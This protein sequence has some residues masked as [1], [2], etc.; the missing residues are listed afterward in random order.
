MVALATFPAMLN[1]MKRLSLV[2]LLLLFVPSAP[3][4][5]QHPI[6]ALETLYE[7]DVGRS[8]TFVLSARS[9]SPIEA[10]SFQFRENGVSD[11]RFLPVAFEPGATVRATATLNLS[12]YALTPFARA[13]Y[14]WQVTDA[15]DNILEIGPQPFQYDDSRFAWEAVDEAN[16]NVHGYARPAEQLRAVLDEALAAQALITRQL[17][18]S[19]LA[20]IDVYVY[21]DAEVMKA[22]LPLHGRDS[23]K[24]YADPRHNII[25]ISPGRAYADLELRRL[26]PHEMAHIYIGQII[27]EAFAPAW[28]VEG[29]ARFFE[30]EPDPDLRALFEVGVQGEALYPLAALC[31]PFPL[32]YTGFTLAYAQSYEVVRYIEGRFG[33]AGIRNLLEAYAQG[34]SCEGGVAQGLGLSLAA[35][36]SDWLRAVRSGGEETSSPPTVWLWIVLL[37]TFAG[38]PAIFLTF[39]WRWAARRGTAG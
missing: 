29:L 14:W 31:P 36:E 16:I 11:V 13:T 27:G 35:L 18:V 6:V 2:C 26:I 38:W 30:V 4:A 24:G 33:P 10:V 7:V 28:L 21:D 32:D 34:A 17:Q 19:E 20:V 9:A 39:R 23:I 15:A 12:E 37:L 22:A 1:R 5:A 8:V 25:L 3:A